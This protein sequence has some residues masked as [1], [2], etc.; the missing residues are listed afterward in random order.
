MEDAKWA[1]FEPFLAAIRWRGRRPASD[2][3]RILDAIFWI[4]PTDLPWRDLSEE[5]GK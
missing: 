5:F 1:F 2:H 4:A 3:R